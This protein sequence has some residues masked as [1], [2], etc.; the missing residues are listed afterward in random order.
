MNTERNI[1]ARSRN[2]YASSAN[3]RAW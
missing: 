1:V 2:V 3:I